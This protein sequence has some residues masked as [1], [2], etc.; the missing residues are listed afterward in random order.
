MTADKADVPRCTRSRRASS[1]CALGRIGSN[2]RSAVARST[3]RQM[4]ATVSRSA[5]SG[6]SLYGM[7]T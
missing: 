3:M 4:A 5:I 1:V 7:I 2:A 6:S